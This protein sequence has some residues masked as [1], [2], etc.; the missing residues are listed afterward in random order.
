MEELENVRESRKV[1]GQ[2]AE[3]ET[4]DMPAFKQVGI[5]MITFAKGKLKR[6]DFL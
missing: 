1:F 2:F 4:P 6:S 5:Q 3:K